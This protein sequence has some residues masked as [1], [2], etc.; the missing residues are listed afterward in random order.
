MEKAFLVF[1]KGDRMAEQHRSFVAAAKCAGVRPLVRMWIL[2]SDPNSSLTLG[3][4]QGEADQHVFDSSA[5]YTILQMLTGSG[6]G[7]ST[8]N[9]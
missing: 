3:K 5:P 8:S 9:I 7:V 2:V 1:I 4:W 6:D